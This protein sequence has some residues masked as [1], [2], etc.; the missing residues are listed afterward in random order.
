MHDVIKNHLN[1]Y[2]TTLEEDK[3]ILQ[4]IEKNEKIENDKEKVEK[5]EKST[6]TGK[7]DQKQKE[8]RLKLAV[9]IRIS[10]KETFQNALK[11]LNQRKIFVG[12]NQQQ[13]VFRSKQ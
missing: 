10:E 13:T 2:P 11:T 4:K 12:E 1:D 9:Q 3:L 8:H 7:V 5:E 6:R